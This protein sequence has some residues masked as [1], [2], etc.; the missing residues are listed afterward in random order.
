MVL[1]CNL[2]RTASFSKPECEILDLDKRLYGGM[3][4]YFAKSIQNKVTGNRKRLP[5]Y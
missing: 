4:A 1:I 5:T 2:C 3:I